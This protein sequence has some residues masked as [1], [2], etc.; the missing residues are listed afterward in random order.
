MQ[1]P[2][3]DAGPP[4]DPGAAF[5]QVLLEHQPDVVTVVLS[6]D[7]TIR[8]ATPS[9][10]SLFGQGP[11]IGARLPDL[12]GLDDRPGV[13]F[14]LDEL[15]TGPV[16]PGPGEQTWPLTRQDGQ[17]IYLQVRSSDL[18][19]VSAVGGLV[20]TFR[21]VTG[22][23]D[24]EAALRR[25]AAYDALTGLPNRTLFADQAVKAVASAA[26][27]GTTAAILLVDLDDFK[28]VNTAMGHRA[29][30]ELLVAAAARLAGA[31]RESDTAARW[32][33]DEFA[34]VLADLPGPAAAGKF[35]DRIVSAFSAPFTLAAGQVS[36]SVSVGA[37]TTADS[38]DTA[39]LLEYADRALYVAKDAGKGTWRA[40]D[41][42]MPASRQARG[43]A[44]R[45]ADLEFPDRR[46]G[47]GGGPASGGPAAPRRS[48]RGRGGSPRPPRPAPLA[49][50]VGDAARCPLPSGHLPFSGGRGG[51]RPN[52]C[53]PGPT[54][55]F[56]V[57]ADGSPPSSVAGSRAGSTARPA[58]AAATEG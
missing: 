28:A 42:T 2:R 33:G 39:W 7:G 47:I 29:G 46:P 31:V 37:A 15:T 34:V 13:A 14:A 21:D 12:V 52:A 8:Y 40:Y 50:P 4:L 6:A 53:R 9:A 45:L 41:K 49:A 38:T 44:G 1:P 3:P 11:L 51:G 10:S 20:L 27:G 26:S 56:P 18:R 43:R 19:A 16:S 5:F 25:M 23:R 30:D 57:I 54:R 35:A 17:R 48:G 55:R 32:G 58:R 24:R 22:Q 36:V